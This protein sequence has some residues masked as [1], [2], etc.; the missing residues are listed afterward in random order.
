MRSL[1]AR[2]DSPVIIITGNRRE[3]ADNVVGLE[4]GAD[5]YNTSRSACES[6]SRGARGAPA[7][8]RRHRGGQTQGG[9]LC[10]PLCR[11]GAIDEGAAAQ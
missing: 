3:E 7:R 10:L 4:L 11:L 6:C 1:S 8:G 2:V 5:D 9:P